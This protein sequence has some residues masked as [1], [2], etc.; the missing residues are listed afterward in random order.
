[1]AHAITF[2]GKVAK[3][4]IGDFLLTFLR[5]WYFK[6]TT[7]TIQKKMKLHACVLWIW[8]N[9]ISYVKSTL[10]VFPLDLRQKGIDVVLF[11]IVGHCFAAR[12]FNTVS[13]VLPASSDLQHP[14]LKLSTLYTCYNVSFRQYSMSDFKRSI[15]RSLYSFRVMHTAYDR[16]KLLVI[17]N[18][19]CSLYF[20]VN[21]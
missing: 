21:H 8:L 18:R 12:L 20:W 3:Y 19:S 14:S 4:L 10:S 16:E 1:M 6:Y 7:K 13:H 2:Q 17:K 9:Y 15:K 11:F 5:R